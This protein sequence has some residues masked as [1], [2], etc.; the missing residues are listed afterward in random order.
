MR[1][2]KANEKEPK[3]EQ[4]NQQTP[5]EQSQPA[6]SAP[7]IPQLYATADSGEMTP[8]TALDFESDEWI[9]SIYSDPHRLSLSVKEQCFHNLDGKGRAVGVNDERVFKYL[10]H[11]QHIVVC[12]GIPHIYRDGYYQMDFRGR[13]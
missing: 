4:G 9:G 1:K 10:T 2:A 8:L 13:K 11:T 6:L 12:D 3:P 7:A 5:P